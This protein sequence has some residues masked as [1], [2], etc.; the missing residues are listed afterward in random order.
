MIEIEQSLPMSLETL[1]RDYADQL[2]RFATVLVGPS[3]AADIVVDAFM[4]V[5]RT[6]TDAF[7]VNERAYLYRACTNRAHDLRRSRERR[8]ARDLAAVVPSSS[9][10]LDPLVDVRRAVAALSLGQRSVVYFVYWEDLTERS[11]AELLGVS[12]G[13]VRRHLARAQANLRKALT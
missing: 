3:D 13:T 1:W 10:Q 11:I 7:V 12:P 4:A 5:S 8:W 9:E 2:M 6:A